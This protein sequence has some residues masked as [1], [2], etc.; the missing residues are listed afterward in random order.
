MFTE[1]ILSKNTQKRLSGRPILSLINRRNMNPMRIFPLIWLILRLNN[2][3]IREFQDTAYY[4]F[5]EFKPNMQTTG[6]IGL[7]CFLILM[8]FLQLSAGA[9]GKKKL[10]I[11]GRIVPEA[12]VSGNGTIEVTKNGAETST[13]TVPK[14]GKFRFELDFFND[15]SLNF[16]YPG[17]FNKIVNV[18][19]V[20]PQDVWERDNDFP[21][22]TMVVQLVKELEGIDKSFTI[23]PSAR[24]F[25]GKSTDN[26]ESESF[27]SD[28]QFREQIAAAKLQAGQIQKEEKSISKEDA[29]DLA[30]RQKDFD[31]LIKEAD[32][33]YQ[34]GEYL[35][36]LSKY[37]SARNLFPEKAYP[38]DRVAELQ[39]LVKALENTEKQKAELE[40]KYKSSIAKANG[41]F[42][43]KSYPEARPVYQ[44]ALQYKPGDA[45]ANGRINE[46]DQQLALQEK[47]K[48][49]KDL[50]AKA[51]NN[52]QQK[53]YDQAIVLYTQAK[54]IVPEN[55][56][57]Q[58]QI[59]LIN[60]EKQQKAQLDQLEKD[61]NQALQTGNT[62]AQQ[63]NFLQAL[64]SYQKALELKPGSQLAQDKIVEMNQAIAAAETDKKY[65]QTIQLADK[66]FGSKEYD[67]A[68]LVYTEALRIKPS[69]KY[70]ADQ[71]AL[72]EKLK[73]EQTEQ[74]YK[75]AIAKADQSFSSNLFDAAATAYQE[76]LTYKKEDP[77][78]TRRLLEIGQKKAD[79]EA[80]NNRLKKLDEDYKTLIADAN[81]KFRNKE[82][83]VSKAKYE[84]AL[85]LKPTETYPKDQ[86][87]QIDLLLAQQEKAR[88]LAMQKAQQDSL[89]QAKNK[90]FNAV[91][92]E[93]KEHEQNKRYGEAL[94]KYK[95]AIAIKPDQQP[96]IQKNIQAIEDQLQL[97]TRQDA[98]YKRI[99]GIA[100]DFYAGQKLS[101]AL[102]EYR[103]ATTI[104][105]AEEYPKS[106]IQEIQSLL[107]ERAQN[108]ANA[109]K[110]YQDALAKAEKSLQDD[111]LPEARL[112]FEAAQ[113]LKPAE[114]LPAERIKVIDRL[115]DQREK[116][117]L[118]QALRET[119]DKYRQAISLADHSFRQKT[120]AEA[121][122]QYLE[123]SGI[124]P[125][126]SYPKNQIALIDKLADEARQAEIAAAQ[127][128]APVIA[129]VPEKPVDNPAQSAQTTEA[130]AQSFKIT[131]DYD[132]AVKKAD[133]F[134]G[135]K[136][137]TVARFYYS[138]A[139][140]IK[141]D[142]A[143]PKSQLELIRKLINSQLSANDNSGYDQAISEADKA[144]AGK[145]YPIAKFFYYKALDIKSWE[146]Y[147]K[148]RVHEI[149]VLT[150]SLLSEKEEAE[151]RD[152]VAKADEA[153]FNKEMAIAR[154]YY[155]RAIAVK[156]DENY[157]Q[158]KL[159]EIQKL[160]EQDASNQ[161]NEKYLKI[162]SEA[163][164]ALKLE[165]YSLARFN[166]NKALTL[167]PNEKY[168]KDQLKKIKEAL[169]KQKN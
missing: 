154:F 53:N 126:E 21:P 26:F 36:A 34:R 3:V 8:I 5:I 22:F 115:L 131:T 35:L 68:R 69:E 166:Y 133:E 43:R 149:Q 62:Q 162:I 159:K 88:T 111:L 44:E 138:T 56:Y 71:L 86:I 46:I 19:T 12:E 85:G 63:K 118:A 67:P 2:P 52:Y 119:E 129:N 130:R 137:Y 83:Q 64:T 121:R 48:Q 98:E 113:T 1:N 77:Y 10:V 120:Y 155:N 57:P 7:Y 33:H 41:L 136:D 122:N 139:N 125:E 157:P 151:Y 90:L 65:Q 13:I 89:L 132:Q 37:R 92:S 23:K 15:Y 153:F 106:K 163:D 4:Y 28:A 100:D 29:Q 117:R 160:I 9:Q 109:E 6:R 14:N 101:E 87:V 45:F 161:E 150:N 124:K 17:N 75:A 146:Q 20:L 93:A 114:K 103:N 165:N 97:L 55:P 96:T 24:I 66:H 18:S 27:L 145:N 110:A 143:Y 82:Y 38:N 105:P 102:T 11:T 107:A 79:T 60:Q 152:A 127:K 42:D 147:P 80:E 167:K 31:Q 123:A 91:V 140:E 58:N 51:D 84:Q 32:T 142:E 72:I 16:K 40:Q 144:F 141:P 99:I 112:Q 30:V 50:I 39:D 168:P 128:P 108:D 94:L 61:F 148:D 104:K 95:E 164:E 158:I 81:N 169:D 156:R 76:A 116:A 70:P 25:Y 54:P 47:Q 74:N 78:A 134:F 59:D 49:Y 135:I 73:T